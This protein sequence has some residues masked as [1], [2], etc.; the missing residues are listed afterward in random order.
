[1]SVKGGKDKIYNS[2]FERAKER[3]GEEE[4]RAL[5]LALERIAEDVWRVELFELGI[6]E[7]PSNPPRKGGR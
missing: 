1:M 4:A 5:K 6:D 2:F 7:E 3:W